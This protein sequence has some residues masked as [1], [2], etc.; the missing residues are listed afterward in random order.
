MMALLSHGIYMN[1]TVI[2]AGEDLACIYLCLKVM[3]IHEIQDMLILC[4]SC[5][6]E[7]HYSQGVWE[8]VAVPLTQTVQ[9]WFVAQS[10]DH[11]L[12]RE[13]VQMRQ[14]LEAV[15]CCSFV[16]SERAEPYLRGDE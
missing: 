3:F 14:A 16:A 2:L 12:C 6:A 10:A 9:R 5:L 8:V 11:S 1:C 4:A 15:H 13:R 7:G